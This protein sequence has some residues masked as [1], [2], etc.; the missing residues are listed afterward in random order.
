[1]VGDKVVDVVAALP[2]ANGQ[3]TTE[4]G[5]EDAYQ[6]IV[7]KVLSDASMASIMGSEHYLVLEYCQ[8]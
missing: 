7:H 6:G 8:R 1:M 3:T 5:N 4:V 2:P